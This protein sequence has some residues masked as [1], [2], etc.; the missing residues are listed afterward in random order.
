MYQSNAPTAAPELMDSVVPLFSGARDLPVAAPRL[1]IALISTYTPRKCGIATFTSD[2]VSQLAA[3]QP[4][5]AASVYALDK[6]AQAGA[7]APDAQWVDQDSRRA[8]VAAADA[9]NASGVGAVWL[10]HEFGI[11]GG[12]DGEL[13]LELVDCLAAPL[14]VTFHTVLS[15]PSDNQRR[16]VDHLVTRSSR[17]MVMSQHGRQLLIDRYGAPGDLIEVIPHGAHDRPFGREDAFKQPLGMAGKN[18][19]MTFGLLGPGKGL[20]QVINALP[21]IVARHPDTVYRIVGATHPNLVASHGEEYREGLIAMA[22]DL[23]VAGHIVWDN[24]FLDTGELLDQLEACDIYVTPYFNLQQATSG[25]LSYAVALGKA[26]VS[27]PYVHARELLSGGIGVLVEPN[28]SAAIA[29]AVACLLDDRDLLAATKRRAYAAGR[30][31][32][33]PAFAAAAGALARKAIVAPRKVAAAHQAPSLQAFTNMCD[34]TGMLQHS[35]GI[36][37]DRRHGYCIDDNARALILVNHVRGLGEADRLARSSTF[38]SFIQYAWN[39]EL[40]TFRNFM[41]FNRG[42]C[43]E[44]GSEDSNGRTLWALGDTAVHSPSPELRAWAASWFNTA[45]CALD[46]VGSPRALAFGML[47][48]AKILGI[49]PG[50]QAAQQLMSRGGDLL[51]RLLARSRR[52][53]WAWFEA[54]LGYDNPR[55]PQALIAAG[56][57]LGREHWRAEG[58]ATLAWIAERQT[59]AQGQFRPVGSNSFGLQYE[60]RPFDQQPLEAQAAIEACAAAYA[61]DPAQRW[62]DHAKAAYD[63]FFGANDRGAVL[64]DL[65]TG[66]CYDGVTPRGANQNTGAESILALQLAHVAYVRL[67]TGPDKRSAKVEFASE[68][69]PS[70]KSAAHP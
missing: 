37:P 15:D 1:K 21:A 23:G 43:E 34:D 28:S 18:V 11:F 45:L 13:V 36:V 63:W 53:D 58:L 35:I 17:I 52:P 49:E 22:D 46:P 9:I 66:R 61:T 56:V 47:G 67:A 6:P 54:V 38:A 31:T 51:F 41:S 70:A 64:V 7:Y 57:A 14:I 42:W 10:Q 68:T 25:T 24:R 2:L 50:H 33:W 29:T 40:R 16:I 8:Y 69:E 19:L 12:R 44:Q 60:Q 62:T 27:T 20:E 65:A 59:S 55:L 39:P 5:I 4:D 30:Q 32:I 3:Y 48:A 26:V